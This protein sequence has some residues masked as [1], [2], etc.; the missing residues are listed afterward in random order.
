MDKL[1]LIAIEDHL[2]AAI[3]L[4]EQANIGLLIYLLNVALL[5]VQDRIKGNIKPS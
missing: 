3:M 5:D 2:K 1:K 4:A